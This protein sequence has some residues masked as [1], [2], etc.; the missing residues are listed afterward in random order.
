MAVIS[1][2]HGSLGEISRP[3]FNIHS[4]L[5][6]LVLPL[7]CDSAMVQGAT[8]NQY[9]KRANDWMTQFALW[10]T[11]VCMTCTENKRNFRK[12]KFVYCT[13]NTEA[14]WGSVFSK[15]HLYKPFSSL[16]SCSS[17]DFIFCMGQFLF[18]FMEE[19]VGK[20]S[21]VGSQTICLRRN[22]W[23]RKDQ[24]AKYK[25]A[26][27]SI[28]KYLGDEEAANLKM[29]WESLKGKCTMLSWEDW[30]VSNGII[31]TL[32]GQNYSYN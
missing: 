8:T 30:G 6:F 14:C 7:H 25:H 5:N 18:Y 24:I 31:V 21:S 32:I 11:V 17:L 28:I 15:K 23:A 3:Y 29:T 27:E 12:L 16:D 19:V 20:R 1:L 26:L 2:V 9:L 13:K 4:K 22:V 10:Y